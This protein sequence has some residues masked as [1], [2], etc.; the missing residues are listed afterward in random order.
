MFG[1]PAQIKADGSFAIIGVTPG[2][3]LLQVRGMGPD[4]EAAFLDITVNG[5]DV[6]GLRLVAN[7]PSV[8][9]GRVVVDPAAAQ[10]LRPSTLRLGLQPV[11][12]DMMMMGG[13]PP[14]PVNDDLTFELKTLPGQRRVALMG[15]TTPGW[16]PRAARRAPS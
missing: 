7:R 6:N 4:S 12:L 2:R 3:Y 13:T 8:V 11:D 16:T 14:A 15:P 5:D 9:S 10:A 1:P